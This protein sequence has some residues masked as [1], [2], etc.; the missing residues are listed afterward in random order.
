MKKYFF[1]ILILTSLTS[2][3]ASKKAF[4]NTSNVS[5][6]SSHI[7]Y[8]IFKLDPA[9]LLFG[10]DGKIGIGGLSGLHLE[11]VD[12]KK[13]KI[14]FTSH[15]DRGS[16][17]DIEK[18][19][20]YPARRFSVPQFAPLIVRL[21][22][23]TQ[24]KSLKVLEQIPLLNKNGKF[25]TGLP[26][27]DP[28]SQRKDADEIPLNAQGNEVAFDPMGLD[29]E[30]IT[31]DNKKDIWMC[32][33]YRPSIL[34]FSSNYM[35]IDRFVPFDSH[36]KN[37]FFGKEAL[38][39]SLRD[40]QLNRG[41]E[42]IAFDGKKI[43]AFLQSP[44]KKSLDDKKLKKQIPIIEFDIQQ[45]KTTSEYTYELDSLDA[46]KIGDA[47]A[48]GEKKFLVVEQNSKTGD[49][50][51]HK[52]YKIS[53][54]KGSI[55]EKEFVIDLTALGLNQVEKIEGL[56]RVDSRTLA[57]VTDNDFSVHK[58]IETNLILI[59]SDTDLF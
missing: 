54:D 5:Q 40:R 36:E 27:L 29:L 22:L 15:T 9:P 42:A 31:K 56:A 24:S 26:N 43:F 55:A 32:E 51:I 50:A 10:G 28:R 35:L 11:S 25:I 59:Q 46:D 33:E 52:I 47:V 23:N 19:D 13:N 7:S 8:Q 21:E 34:H 37:K 20:G 58:K 38:P 6:K 44:L 53:L 3:C 49:K 48:L 18:K 45:K 39:S 30:G 41:F 12:R 14:I 57:L 17:G 2:S 16:N 1:L 4:K